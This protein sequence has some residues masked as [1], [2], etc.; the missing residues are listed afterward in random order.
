VCL[1]T[2]SLLS[3]KKP[4]HHRELCSELA[5]FVGEQAHN[6]F[7]GAAIGEA[8]LFVRETLDL[9]FR[10]ERGDALR[11]A[12]QQ[13]TAA[14]MKSTFNKLTRRSRGIPL[15]TGAKSLFEASAFLELCI[16]ARLAVE[17]AEP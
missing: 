5:D 17:E 3:D 8:K 12:G 15:K 4:K 2:Y 16:E 14:E 10:I 7:L 1:Q 9:E 6:K 11:R 13:P